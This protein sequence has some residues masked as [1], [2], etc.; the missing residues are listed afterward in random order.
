MNDGY[1]AISLGIFVI[2]LIISAILHGFSSVIDDV[3]EGELEEKALAGDKRSARV[4]KMLDKR[5]KLTNFV[6]VTAIIMNMVTGGFVF[7]HMDMMVRSNAGELTQVQ[8]FLVST[9]VAGILFVMMAVFGIMVPKKILCRNSTKWSYR[10]INLVTFFMIIMS[11]V[12]LIVTGIS[13][14]LVKLLGGDINDD[15]DNVTEEGIITMVN[16]GQEQGVLLASEAEMITNIVE[17]GD[18]EAKDIMTHRKNICALDGHMTLSQI[19]EEIVGHSFSR[20]PVYDRDIDDIVGVLHFKDFVKVHS[21]GFKRNYSLLELKDEIMY[22]VEFVP[23]TK[24]ID[25]LFRYM[26]SS[27]LHMAVVVDEYG[28]TSGIVTMEDIL[29]EIVG[30]IMDEHDAD[31]DFIHVN[32]NDTYEMEGSTLLEDIEELLDIEFDNED[33]ETL[34][35]FLIHRMEHLPQEDEEFF[36]DY[37]GYRFAIAYVHD[38]MIKKVI[39]TRLEAAND[40]NTEVNNG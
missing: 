5:V 18:K 37:E 9:L 28:Q 38:K 20:Y 27:K 29:E 30:N 17:Y 32:A 21:D 4:L 34:N 33:V 16:E 12:T 8:G 39:V 14:G 31:T 15:G 11:P 13:N 10:L 2:F 1:P 26:Q 19:F 24:N 40:E 3:N 23:E 22:Q 7:V 35:G 6:H 36:T 25:D